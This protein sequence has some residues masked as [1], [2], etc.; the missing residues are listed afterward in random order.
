MTCGWAYNAAPLALVYTRTQSL[1]WVGAAGF[2]RFVPSLL[3][4]SYTGIVNPTVPESELISANALQSTIGNLMVII[5]RAR[6]A[7]WSLCARW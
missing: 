6:R 1:A 7:R 2:V 4:S 3:L 5:G